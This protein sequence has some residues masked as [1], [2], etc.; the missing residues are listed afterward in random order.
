MDVRS[1]DDSIVFD[2]KPHALFVFFPR[3]LAILNF[4]F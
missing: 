1:Q 2:N 3:N 4:E